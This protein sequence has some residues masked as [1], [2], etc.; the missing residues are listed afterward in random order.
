MNYKNDKRDPKK[1]RE[2]NATRVQMRC[3]PVDEFRADTR[4]EERLAELECLYCFYMAG[5]IGGCAM[6]TANCGECQK[7][8]LFGST[9]VDYACPECAKKNSICKHCGAEM[10]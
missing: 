1:M 7:E 6:T 5:R 3:R 4:K 2:H 8:M 10:D 9:C